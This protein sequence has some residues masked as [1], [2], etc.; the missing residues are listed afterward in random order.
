M[1]HGYARYRTAATTPKL[2]AAT[3][4]STTTPLIGAT[5]SRRTSTSPS[6]S[7]QVAAAHGSLGMRARRRT[8]CSRLLRQAHGGK[9]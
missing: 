4:S 5:T 6:M 9:M 2:A 7:S 3:N 1:S 8:S